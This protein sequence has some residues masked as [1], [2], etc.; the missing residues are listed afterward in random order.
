MITLATDG[1]QFARD[2]DFV[3]E[4][5][6]HPEQPPRPRTVMM[7]TAPKCSTIRAGLTRALLN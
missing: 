2:A 1:E 6:A 4:A 5:L 7:T 3:L